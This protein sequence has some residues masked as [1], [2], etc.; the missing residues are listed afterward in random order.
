VGSRPE[1]ITR[2]AGGIAI[3]YGDGTMTDDGSV[4]SGSVTVDTSGMSTGPDHV[5]GAATITV[6]DLRVNGTPV[7]T[8]TAWT[9][10]LEER[11]DGTVVGEISAEPIGGNSAAGSVSGSITV[12]TA[13]CEKYPIS[14]SLTFIS[15]GHVT[16]IAPS[17]D[18]DGSLVPDV[19]VMPPG[20]DFVFTSDDPWDPSSN[21]FITS[22]SNAE[23]S[24]E[25]DVGGYW[26]PMVGA[27][28]FDTTTPGVITFHYGFD[29]PIAQGELLLTLATFHFWYSQGHAFLDGSTDGSSWQQL[30]E[31]EPPAEGLG[32]GGGWSGPLPTMFIGATDIWLRVRLYSYGPEAPTGGVYCNTAQMFRYDPRQTSN[33]FELMVDLQ[34]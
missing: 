32:R 24:R 30:V 11:D 28:T 14:G 18:C 29:R 15:D 25:G 19:F 3:D 1:V 8:S 13:I 4:W 17:P 31:V 12:D 27:E 2:T 7:G 21:A 22:V 5:S 23:V 16:T 6:D 20:F 26:R 10:D 33:T 9:V 34:D